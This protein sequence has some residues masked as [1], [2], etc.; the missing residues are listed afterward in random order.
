MGSESLVFDSEHL[1]KLCEDR[2]LNIEIAKRQNVVKC[3]VE[4][5]P[6]YYWLVVMKFRTVQSKTQNKL[7]KALL[8]DFTIQQWFDRGNGGDGSEMKYLR[9][10]GR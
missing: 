10:A 8:K 7:K 9:I 6:E 3:K 4:E 1:I 2:E 5:D